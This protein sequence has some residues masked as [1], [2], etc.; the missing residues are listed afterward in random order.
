MSVACNKRAGSETS[1]AS[2]CDP[3]TA[4]DPATPEIVPE[5]IVPGVVAGAAHLADERAVGKPVAVA[6]E[7][8]STRH[9][10]ASTVAATASLY[11]AQAPVPG[12]P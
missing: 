2:G 4:L 6:E 1:V 12:K 9:D 11:A 10:V 8:A 5:R 7:T 3:E